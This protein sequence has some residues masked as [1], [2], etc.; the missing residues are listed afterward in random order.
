MANGIP[1]PDHGALAAQHAAKAQMASGWGQF[2]IAGNESARAFNEAFQ[3]RAAGQQIP[4]RAWSVMSDAWGHRPVQ[5]CSG[6]SCAWSPMM[7]GSGIRGADGPPAGGLDR[8]LDSIA[9]QVAGDIDLDLDFDDLDND[10]LDDDELDEDIYGD[11]YGAGGSGTIRRFYKNIAGARKALDN[12]RENNARRRMKRAMKKLARIEAKDNSFEPTEDA[13]QMMCWFRTGREDC[14]GG[15]TD[16]TLLSEAPVQGQLQRPMM[17]R[18]A[19]LPGMQRPAMRPGVH[20]LTARLEDRERALDSRERDLEARR[21]KADVMRDRRQDRR[22][23]K[24]QEMRQDKRQ[25]KRQEMRQDRRQDKRQGQ[26]RK[27]PMGGG[28]QQ[29]HGT[30]RDGPGP[31]GSPMGG[32]QGMRGQQHGMRR[33][34]PGPGGSPMGGSQG[35]RGQQQGT[36]GQQQGARRDGPGPGGSPM[37]GSQGARNHGGGGRRDSGGQGGGGQHEKM[38]FMD[39]AI[40]AGVREALEG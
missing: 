38:G 18:P 20:Q 25:D 9:A 39:A 26:E 2:N 33:D 15:D 12:G 30:R 14:D 35:V 28:Q 23:D 10:D 17:Q 24:R 32:S 40:Y 37:G 13:R 3:A 21:R 8:T 22:Q 19:M 31:G 1:V 29:Q 11:I 6:Y 5:P 16:T 4:E 34:G 36:R 7:P 27:S